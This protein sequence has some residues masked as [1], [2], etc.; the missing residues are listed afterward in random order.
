MPELTYR[1]GLEYVPPVRGRWMRFSFGYEFDYW[2]N[3]GNTGTNG[4]LNKSS[5]IS[6]SREDIYLQGIFFRGEFAF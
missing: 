2:W 4:Y 1:L 5:E 3:V 6:P